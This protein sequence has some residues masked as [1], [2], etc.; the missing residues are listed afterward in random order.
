MQVKLN[1]EALELPEAMTILQLLERLKVRRDIVAVEVNREIV[2]RARHGDRRLEE[3]DAVE[4]VT[5]VG[6]G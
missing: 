1:G 5:F 6:G 3:G 4:V 2:P